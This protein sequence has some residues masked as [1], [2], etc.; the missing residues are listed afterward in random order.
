M[1]WSQGGQ[2]TLIGTALEP[3][4][5]VAASVCGWSPFRSIGGAIAENLA[6]PYNYPRLKALAAEG[7]CLAMDMD[8]VAASIAPRAFLNFSAAE[9]L[10]FPNREVTREA[11]DEIARAYALLGAP[12]RFRALRVEGKHAFSTDAARETQA[13]MYRFLWSA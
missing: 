8:H 2:M 7:R 3:R 5:A 1:G 9:D 12:E 4:I 6:M 13:W 11:E 10:Y